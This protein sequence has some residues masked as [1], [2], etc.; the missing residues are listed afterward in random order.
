MSY[1]KS[2]ETKERL[3][4]AMGRLLRVQGYHATGISQILAESGVPK[5]S[6][7]HHYPDGK[8][9]L[10]AAAVELSNGRIMTYLNELVAAVEHPIKT[11]EVFCHYYMQQLNESGFMKGCPIA[12]VT[13]ETAAMIDPIQTSCKQAF[14]EMTELFSALLESHGVDTETAQELGVVAICSIEGALILCRANRNTRP[15]EMVRDNIIRQLEQV[16]G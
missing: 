10:A 3:L 13:L 8:A 1:A 6:L 16:L 9:E 2:E 4:R 12:T 15:L 7:Y 5:G 11:I 14:E